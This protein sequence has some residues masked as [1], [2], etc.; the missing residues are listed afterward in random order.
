MDVEG[1]EEDDDV[2]VEGDDVEEEDPSQV[3]EAHFVRACAVVMGMDR[4]QEK[5]CVEIYRNNAGRQSRARH[6]VRACA[7]EMHMDMSQEPFCRDLQEKGPEPNPAIQVLRELAQSK[8]TCHTSQFVSKFRRQ[9]PDAP[10]TTSIEH[11]A[12]TMTVRTL[13]VATLFGEKLS[14]K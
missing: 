7:I 3:R 10:D 11:R 14:L 13:S 5:F 2:D 9:M 6:F 4:V 12:S 8:C 1:E